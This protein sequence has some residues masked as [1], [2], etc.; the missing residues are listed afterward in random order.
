[1]RP[2]DIGDTAYIRISYRPK[3]VELTRLIHAHFQHCCTV[4]DIKRQ[5]RQG[6]ANKII[7]ISFRFQDTV[8]GM[9]RSFRP[10]SGTE[11]KKPSP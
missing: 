3:S 9:I 6:Q 7:E 5:Q 11:L 2:M 8:S 1:M 10:H 4:A